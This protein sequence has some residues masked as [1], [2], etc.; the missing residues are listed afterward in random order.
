MAGKNWQASGKN[1]I[2]ARA[3][4]CLFAA[5]LPCESARGAPLSG[6]GFAPASYVG[7]FDPNLIWELV[8]GAIVMEMRMTSAAT[9]GA[10]MMGRHA[11]FCVFFIPVLS[12][13]PL[14]GLL[15]VLRN[16]APDNPGL[17]GAAAGLAAGGIAAAIY[18]WHCPDDSPLFVATWYTTAIAIV[19]MAG[20][21]IGRRLLR[22]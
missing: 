14:T 6:G 7:A 3:V 17:A 21:L 15:T 19:T 22:W 12:L 16:G 1:S 13:A 20:A 8:I 11:P 18:A 5:A 10:R 9:W 4:M 2:P